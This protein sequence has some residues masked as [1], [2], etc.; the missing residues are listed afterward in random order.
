MYE[1]ESFTAMATVEI[2]T[3]WRRGRLD[4]QPLCILMDRS[5]APVPGLGPSMTWQSVWE[6][7]EHIPP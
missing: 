5:F 3:D 2:S 6:L 1:T 4:N 7:M